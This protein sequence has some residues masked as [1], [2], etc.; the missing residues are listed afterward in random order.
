M[1]RIFWFGLGVLARAVS[2]VAGLYSDWIW[3][4][5][6]EGAEYAVDL[7][8]GRTRRWAKQVHEASEPLDKGGTLEPPKGD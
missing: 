5:L 4:K 7:P 2:I 8:D 1:P 6:V 3:N